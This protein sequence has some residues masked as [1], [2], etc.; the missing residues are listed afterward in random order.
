[1]S[2]K[3]WNEVLRLNARYTPALLGLAKAAYKQGNY[4]RAQELFLEAGHTGGYSDAFWQS[5]LEWFQQNFGVL[6]NAAVIAAIAFYALKR[7]LR[8]VRNRRNQGAVQGESAFADWRG[9]TP[10]KRLGSELRHAFYIL[11]HPIDGFASIRYESKAGP[12][13]SLVMLLSALA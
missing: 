12:A 4:A 10:L 9:W 5:R 7:V 1:Q 3:L 11:K 2:S 6:M 8:I 13:G